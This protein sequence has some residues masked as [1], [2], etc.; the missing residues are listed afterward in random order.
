MNALAAFCLAFHWNPY[1]LYDRKKGGSERI[2][3]ACD[4]TNLLLQLWFSASHALLIS[5]RFILRPLQLD[6]ILRR[7]PWYL[8]SITSSSAFVLAREFR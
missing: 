1:K 2:I 6:F 4:N 5:P 3:L 8:K 7:L